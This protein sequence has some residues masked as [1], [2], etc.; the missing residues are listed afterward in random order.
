MDISDKWCPQGSDLGPELFNIFIS[1]IGKGIECTL[2]R[3]V[4]DSELRG[5]VDTPEGWDAIQRDLDKLEKWA[6]GIF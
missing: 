4:G 6:H 2:S 3:F 5:A 1:D